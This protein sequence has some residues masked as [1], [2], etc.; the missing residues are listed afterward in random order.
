MKIFAHR[1][2]SERYPENTMLAF[3]KA[4]EAGADGIEL[5]VQLTKEGT[6]VV[7]HDER[8]DR[9]TDGTGFVRD[10]TYEELSGFNAASIRS[11]AAAFERIPT[12]EEY[13]RWVKGTPLITNVE[14]KTGVYYYENIEEKTLELVRRYGLADRIIFS[15]FNHL[16]V[17]KMKELAPEIP[18]GALVEKE[19]IGNAGFYCS[20][21]GLEYYHPDIHGL[22]EAVVKECRDKGVRVNVWT[23]ND[24]EGM[25]RCVRWGCNGLITNDLKLPDWWR[26]AKGAGAEEEKNKITYL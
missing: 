14:L 15:S 23:V 5:D 21:F 25:D 20:R 19:G 8:I 3:K 6:V 1:G 26:K 9:T 13:C 7:I 10:Y 24:L 12:F 18:C 2:Y 4:Y 11:E 16:S 22:D 17:V